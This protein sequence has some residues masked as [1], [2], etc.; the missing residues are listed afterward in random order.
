[1]MS[2]YPKQNCIVYCYPKSFSILFTLYVWPWRIVHTPLRLV[3]RLFLQPSVIFSPCLVVLSVTVSFPFARP[4]VA[5]A[6]FLLIEDLKRSA[7]CKR[8]FT[9]TNAKLMPFFSICHYI[10]LKRCFVT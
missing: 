3:L 5:H 9:F 2:V 10:A 7:F 8:I 6:F 4:F 1:M